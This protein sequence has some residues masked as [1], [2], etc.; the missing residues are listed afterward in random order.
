MF[1][2]QV[3]ISGVIYVLRFISV[4]ILFGFFNAFPYHQFVCGIVADTLS[5]YVIDKKWG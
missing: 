3:F 1:S 4:L 2:R 5:C